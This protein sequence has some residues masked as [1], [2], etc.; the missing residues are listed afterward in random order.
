[1]KKKEIELKGKKINYFDS[2]EKEKSLIFIHGNSLEASLFK[3]QF[4]DEHLGRYRII[5]PDLMGHGSSGRS[6]NPEQDYSVNSYI[7]SI[8]ELINK[9]SLKNVV[10]FGHSLGGH[11]AIHVLEHLK[12]IKGIVI[13]GT[14]PLTI[15]PKLEEAFLPNPAFPLSFKP[16]LPDEEI[17]SLAE[18][19]HNTG[20]QDFDLVTNSI[21]L[22]DPLVRPFI[23][24][25]ISTQ[26]VTDE[27]D[28]LKNAGIPVAIFHGLQDKAVNLQY[29]EK[30]RIPTLWKNKIIK[31]N[32]SHNA[33]IENAEELNKNLND[34]LDSCF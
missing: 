34:F 28:I 32:S 33:F 10:L 4:Q 6:N 7:G 30:L 27:V 9:L 29:L 25:S 16:D 19:F 3:H 11:I 12:N 26:L 15:P 5:A 13:L 21:K 24:K 17:N 2:G 23:G 8:I 1:M 31:I 22:A 20:H 14:P 18:L